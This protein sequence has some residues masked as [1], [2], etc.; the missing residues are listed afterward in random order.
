MLSRSAQ[1]LHLCRRAGFGISPGLWSHWKNHSP[2]RVLELLWQEAAA[3]PPFGGYEEEEAPPEAWTMQQQ[4]ASKEERKAAKKALRKEQKRLLLTG[5]NYDWV[6]RMANPATVGMREKM[7]LFWHGHFAVQT[8]FARHARPYVN[9]LH[10]HA[11][12]KFPDLLHDIARDT[13]MILFLNN[14]QNRKDH[15]N[16]NFAR[17]LME[18]FTL[19]RGHYTETDVREAARAFTGWFSDPLRA[20]FRFEARQHD[21][22][23][24]T[25]FGNTGSWDGDD[26]LAMLV[27]KEATA[28]HLVHKIHRFYVHEN[29]P[30]ARRDQLARRL[31]D[32]GYDFQDLMQHIFSS[33]WFYESENVGNQ[34][35]SPVVLLAGMLKQFHA[36]FEEKLATAAVQ[37]SLGQVLFFPPNVAG[38]PGGKTWIDHA[39]LLLRMQLPS[40]F[41][42]AANQ[43]LRMSGDPEADSNERKVRKLKATVDMQPLLAL[44]YTDQERWKAW[45]TLLL[46]PSS[47]RKLD[48]LG[49]F[50]DQ[51]DPEKSQISMAV[52]LCGLPEYQLC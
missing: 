15:P 19:G 38:W 34:I 47:Q 27:K 40:L 44:G 41:F 39:S 36:T 30:V 33:G 3:T 14:Q 17:E 49:D 1:V 21:A 32:S 9:T 50:A 18:L 29:L 35:K 45:E 28:V 20:K 37:K 43:G 46:P 48:W 42:L 31:F 52:R 22:G 10:Q 4:A 11:F 26:V 51:R 8:V 5:L 23:T 16:E 2:D 13:A 24:K 25:I 7:M 6:M 12:G